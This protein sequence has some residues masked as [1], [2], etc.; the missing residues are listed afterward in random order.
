MSEVFRRRP[1]YSED[2]PNIFRSQ[3]ILRGRVLPNM[4]SFPM[5]FSSKL[6][7]F[8]AGIAI[9][10]FYMVVWFSHWFEIT[11]FGK[12]VIFGCDN[13]HFSTRR[14]KLV[15]KRELVWDRSFQLVGVRLTPKAWE[16]AG[17]QLQCTISECAL[18]K[19]GYFLCCKREINHIFL[20]LQ[21]A[22]IYQNFSFYGYIW[23]VPGMCPG[24]I[25]FRFVL[26]V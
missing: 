23:V 21:P 16:L 10:S 24:S 9:F 26:L 22:T 8:R 14:E 6:C 15:R 13:S 4:T 17:I 18:K 20:L 12:C 7:H 25:F 11:F 1:K 3:Y 2:V 5:L 19:G